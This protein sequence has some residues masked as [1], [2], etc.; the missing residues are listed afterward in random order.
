VEQPE[1][2]LDPKRIRRD[3]PGQRVEGTRRGD[4]EF[5]NGWAGQAGKY[6]C[7]RPNEGTADVAK[8]W[9]GRHGGSL[10]GLDGKGIKRKG[11]NFGFS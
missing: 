3:R 10:L 4:S 11:G 6:S 9:G 1:G 2:T 8:G 5:S 7:R